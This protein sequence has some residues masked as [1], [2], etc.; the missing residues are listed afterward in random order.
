MKGEE[1]MV[2]PK[3]IR[4]GDAIKF[5]TLANGKLVTAVRTV[6]AV[7]FGLVAVSQFNGMRRYPIM[8]HEIESVEVK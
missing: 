7:E 3:D 1:A 6:K 8:A 2:N 5:T 4:P